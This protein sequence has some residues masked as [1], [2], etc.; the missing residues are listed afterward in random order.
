[1]NK[2]AATATMAT[3]NSDFLIF[4]GI[5]INNKG[6]GSGRSARNFR[7]TESMLKAQSLTL[8]AKQRWL[9]SK[10]GLKL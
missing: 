6:P 3:N 10:G 9:F 8:K 5:L 7:G 4:L 1:V 2:V